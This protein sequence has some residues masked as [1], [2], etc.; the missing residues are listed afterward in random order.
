MAGATIA[1]ITK[2]MWTAYKHRT[3]RAR[4][5][6]EM[7]ND[8]ETRQELAGRL[9]DVMKNKSGALQAVCTEDVTS[10]S[11]YDEYLWRSQ[12][13]ICFKAIKLREATRKEVAE[14]LPANATYECH[15]GVSE[16][17][18]DGEE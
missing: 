8:K 1:T 4:V 14:G 2:S 12:A 7:L 11:S 5:V 6:H 3:T 18:V 17:L 9:V 15:R 10:A 13:T 16:V